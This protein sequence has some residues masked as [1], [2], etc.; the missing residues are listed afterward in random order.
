MSKAEIDLDVL[1]LGHNHSYWLAAFVVSSYLFDDLE[2][3]SHKCTIRCMG[4]REASIKPFQ[5]AATMSL[6]FV[7]DPDVVITLIGG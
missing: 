2:R 5:E 3:L 4:Q 1:V 6:S 7:Y